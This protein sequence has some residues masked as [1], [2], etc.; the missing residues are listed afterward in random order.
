MCLVCAQ[1]YADDPWSRDPRDTDDLRTAGGD[2]A[3]SRLRETGQ[4]LRII[5]ELVMPY[6]LRVKADSAGGY[7]V[8]DGKGKTLTASG[9]DALWF[10]LQRDF[11]CHIDVLDP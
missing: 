6:S 7:A 8:S 4:R 3:R 9:L 2:A 5:N 11:G 10:R 1:I